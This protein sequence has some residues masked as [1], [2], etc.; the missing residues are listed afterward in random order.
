M[1]KIIIILLGLGLLGGGGFFGY[2]YFTEG[3][4]PKDVLAGKK[5][6]GLKEEKAVKPK[7]ISYKY[8]KIPA[9][10]VSVMR[11]GEVDKIFAVLIVLEVKGAKGE[12]LVNDR[13][14][15]LRDA[16]YSYLHAASALPD[17]PAIDEAVFI[18]NHLKRVANQIVGDDRVHDVLIQSTFARKV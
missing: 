4:T 9:I 13:M 14:P 15:L 1:K 11:R 7:V 10:N 6:G 17:L 18:K 16:F 8:V 12:T 2:K 3:L 5:P